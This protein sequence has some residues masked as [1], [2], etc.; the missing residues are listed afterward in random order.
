VEHLTVPACLWA[1]DGTLVASNAAARSVWQGEG[2]P[3]FVSI[4]KRSGTAWTGWLPAEN[5]SP[6]VLIGVRADGSQVE[7]LAFP[8]LIRNPAGTVEDVL[9]VFVPLSLGTVPRN[10]VHGLS[11]AVGVILGNVDL[12]LLD[13]PPDREAAENLREIRKAALAA[14]TFLREPGADERAANGEAAPGSRGR[15]LCLDD[16][17]AF[18][19]LARRALRRLGCEVDVHQFAEEALREHART[20]QRW[21]LVLIDNNLVGRSGLE[22]AAGFLRQNPDQKICIAS[23]AVNDDLEKRARDVGVRRVIFKPATVSE[24]AESLG[25]LLPGFIRPPDRP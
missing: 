24:F 20:P 9:E 15:V 23:G 18:L 12:A 4:R 2:A 10:V 13:V 14:R 21:D 25:D 22:A 6:C 7:Y 1:S 3:G 16:D 11:N 19:L 5:P 8:S 17:V